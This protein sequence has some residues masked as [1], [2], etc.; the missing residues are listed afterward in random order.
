[1]RPGGLSITTL[2][3]KILNMTEKQH[4]RQD[5]EEYTHIYL[6]FCS[7]AAN[8][9]VPCVRS[10]EHNCENSPLLRQQKQ[11]VQYH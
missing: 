5:V 6:S 3:L 11:S 2:M 9:S 8:C 4:G 1:V 10:Q 7:S